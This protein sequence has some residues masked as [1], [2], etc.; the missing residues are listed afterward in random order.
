M[1][2]L[3]TYKGTVKKTGYIYTGVG[4]A[5]C[6]FRFE[7]GARYLVYAYENEGRLTTD[8][9]TRT[10]KIKDA[11]D[12][13]EYF[14]QLPNM[15]PGA[16]I[17][18]IVLGQR[19]PGKSERIGISEIRIEVDGPTKKTVLTDRD[20]RFS[21]KGLAPGH[22]RVKAVVPDGLRLSTASLVDL[23]PYALYDDKIV[24]KGCL[25][26]YFVLEPQTGP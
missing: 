24:D 22:Y 17:F 6:G 5:D 26:T 14:G 11:R 13:L 4:D 16:N 1:K 2:V 3:K 10:R 25:E 23:F 20:G 9:C 15:A 12:D 8:I 18:G 7:I 21:V 19:P